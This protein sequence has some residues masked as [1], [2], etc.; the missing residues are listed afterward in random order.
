MVTKKSFLSK[1]NEEQKNGESHPYKQVGVIKHTEDEKEQNKAEQK[2]G[3]RS[4]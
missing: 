1:L 4:H 2:W 3:T